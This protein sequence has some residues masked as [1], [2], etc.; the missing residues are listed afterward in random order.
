VQ[1]RSLATLLLAAALVSGAPTLLAQADPE[2]RFD[3]DILFSYY[4]QDGD[5]SPVTGGIG[6]EELEV[7]SP[8]VV[9]P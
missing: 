3:A 6:T 1:L 2:G 4:S 8:V 5:H 7:A 9:L